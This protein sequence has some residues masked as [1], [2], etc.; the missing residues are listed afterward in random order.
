MQVKKKVIATMPKCYAITML[1]SGGERSFLVATEKAGDCQRF[2]LDGEYIETLWSEPGGIMTMKQIP[3]SNGS[4]LSTHK[5]FSP[6]DSKEALLVIVE[7]LKADGSPVAG[8]S[9][10]HSWKVRILTPLPFVHRFDILTVNGRN[11]LIACCLKSDHEFKEDWNHPGR[12]YGCELPDD[13]SIY[14]E[15]NPLPLEVIKDGLTK[16]HGY[17]RCVM[18]DGQPGSLV[19]A[20]DGIFR[21]APPREAGGAWS[22]EQLTTQATSDCTELDFDGDGVDE[23]L[24]LSPFHGATLRILKPRDGKYET[25][26]EYPGELEFLHAIWSGELLGIP[27]A[28]IGYRR[29]DRDLLAISYNKDKADY[30]VQILDHDIGPTNVAVFEKDGTSYIIGA[31]RETD[32]VALYKVVE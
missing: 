24:T 26:Y 4:F 32:E 12:I 30:E 8:L 1:E 9:E 19:A 21:V 22:V 14:N 17:G 7:P 28:L 20:E 2:T 31:N 29:G 18:P 27:T 10:E 5:F 15:E 25:V 11:Y 13:L 23:L 16:N 6:N 3:G